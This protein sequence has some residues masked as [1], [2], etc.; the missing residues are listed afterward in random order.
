MARARRWW[1]IPAIV[2]ALVVANVAANRVVPDSWYAPFAVVVS[3]ALVVFAVRVDG[4]SFH[5]L[6]MARD[7]APRGLKWGVILL[8]L[9]VVGYLAALVLPATRD[10]FRDER[11]ADMTFLDTLHAAFVRVT[12]GTVL[13]EEVAFRAVLP[14]VLVARTR[15]WI[16]VAVSSVLFGFWHLLPSFG[17]ETVN[18]V[19]E[20]TVGRLPAWVTVGGAVLSTTAVGLWFAFLRERTGSVLTPMI[21]HWSTNALGYLFAYGV[22][23][24]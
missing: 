20:D 1:P 13:L 23:N 12:L 16:A 24:W 4:R 18:P 14:A 3:V 5:D 17:L 22:W 7:Q 9:V 21:A 19:A 6:G 15:L 10:L 8:G 2:L 11:V